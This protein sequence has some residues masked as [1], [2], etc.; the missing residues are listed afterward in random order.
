M[1]KLIPYFFATILI[2]SGLSAF[3]NG[4]DDGVS[5][6]RKPKKEKPKKEKS[7]VRT[8]WT[9]GILPSVAYDADKGFQYGVLA[10]VY[11]FGDGSVYPDYFRTNSIASTQLNIVGNNALVSY[12]S[13]SLEGMKGDR[14]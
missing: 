9:F 5:R 3:A 11:D 12:V 7:E 1:K 4:G 14:Y 10:N 2:I 6:D 13:A 8:G